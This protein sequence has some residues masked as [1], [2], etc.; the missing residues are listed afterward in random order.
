F[1]A[2]AIIV[3]MW[4][5]VLAVVLVKLAAEIWLQRPPIKAA[6]NVCAHAL[7]Q[8]V[9]IAVFLGLGGAGLRTIPNLHDLAHVT[10]VAAAPAMVAFLVA[11]ITNNLIVTRAIAISSGRSSLEVLRVNNNGVRI[12]LDF[13]AWP[14]VFV[15]AWVY[16]AFG[17]IAAA[18]LWVPILGLRQL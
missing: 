15:F 5:T 13:I 8:V 4:P 9:A 12:G 17:G 6:L 1:F 2:S 14:L 18:A 10:R 3:P 11:S 16:A 7:G